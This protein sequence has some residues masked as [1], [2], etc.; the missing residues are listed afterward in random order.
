[1]KHLARCNI[2]SDAQHAFRKARSTESQLILT[3]HDL[4]KNLDDRT[5]TDLAILNFSKAFD[6][7]PHQRLLIKLD[8]CGIRGST[9]RWIEIFLT[10]RQQRVTINGSPSNWENVL[11]GVPQGTVLGPHLF[12]L[13]I[14]DINETVSSN[15]RLFAIDCLV[16]WTIKTSEDEVKNTR[17]PWQSGKLD[18]NTGYA[19]QCSQ[20]QHHA[21]DKPQ[22]PRGMQL[23]N[24]GHNSWFNKTLPI[25]QCHWNVKDPAMEQPSRTQ[26]SPQI[27]LPLRCKNKC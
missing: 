27:D 18:W 16:F 25:P 6:V 9:K 20:M 7:V 15:L 10:K 3:T 11:S 24:D 17:R 1:M 21:C 19:L 12:L 4:T 26:K 13:F 22:K 8:H 2:L 23:Q 14:N 5:T